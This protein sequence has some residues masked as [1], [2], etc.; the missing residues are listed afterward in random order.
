[1]KIDIKNIVIICLGLTLIISCTILLEEIKEKNV[2]IDFYKFDYRKALDDFCYLESNSERA[3][4]HQFVRIVKNKELSYHNNV[5]YEPIIKVRCEDG[6]WYEWKAIKLCP[7]YLDGVCIDRRHYEISFE[8][9]KKRRI[10][11]KE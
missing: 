1:M 5:I 7:R 4:D 3:I 10:E 9:E 8:A 2:L 11:L 6:L